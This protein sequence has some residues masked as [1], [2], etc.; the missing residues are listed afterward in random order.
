MSNVAKVIDKISITNF[1]YG[2]GNLYAPILRIAKYKNNLYYGDNSK[3]IIKLNLLGNEFLMSSEIYITTGYDYEF[4]KEYCV[5]QP[6]KNSN[7]LMFLKESETDFILYVCSNRY[8]TRISAQVLYSNNLGYIEGIYNKEFTISKSSMGQIIEPLPIKQVPYLDNTYVSGGTVEGNKYVK[9]GS[10][11]LFDNTCG[12]NLG[13][14]LM[15]DSNANEEFACGKVYIKYRIQSGDIKVRITKGYGNDYFINDNI[16]VV[17]VHA[18]WENRIDI[19]LHIKKS[20]TGF[21]FRPTINNLNVENV[22]VEFYE[23]QE[24]E[25][26]L[27]NGAQTLLFV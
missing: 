26:Q 22:R 4:K 19:Y 6:L 27:P 2:N 9:I 17:L 10:A 3:F 20:Y 8:K 5:L 7:I 24:V 18:T 1:N 15:E 25:N 13:L 16:N 23:K 11:W 21:I 12:L 14:E